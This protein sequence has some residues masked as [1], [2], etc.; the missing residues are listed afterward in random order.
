MT[1]EE[2]KAAVVKKDEPKQQRAGKG[3]LKFDR[4]LLYKCQI[5]K[6]QMW[7]S[8]TGSTE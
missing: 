1:H 3:V 8:F 4:Y 7:F 2:A 6:I 5:K